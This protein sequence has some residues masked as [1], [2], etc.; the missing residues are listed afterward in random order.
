MCNE[1]EIKIFGCIGLFL[2]LI[3]GKDIIVTDGLQPGVNGAE[4]GRNQ[5]TEFSR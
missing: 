3:S 2:K 5:L 4:R 1:L